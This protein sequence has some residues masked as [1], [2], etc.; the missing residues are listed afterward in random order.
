[1]KSY[2]ALFIVVCSS[3]TSFSQTKG[4]IELGALVGYSS[5]TVQQGKNTNS[6]SRGAMAVGITGDYYFSDRWSIKAKI[7]YDQKGWNRGFISTPTGTST[8]N[9]KLN[10]I[11]IPLMANWHFGKKRNWYL[12]FGP[13]VG[14][15]TSANETALGMNLK[16]D[17]KSTDAGLEIGIGVKIPLAEKAR[18]IIEYGGQ[19][20]LTDIFKQNSSGTAINNLTVNINAGI[21]ISL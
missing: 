17:F 19:G 5:S 15:L 18:F 8:T 2:L 6:V 11:T 9:F 20:G 1:M 13:Y 21:N 10:Y 12:N 7:R 3:S 16:N 14:F 4:K